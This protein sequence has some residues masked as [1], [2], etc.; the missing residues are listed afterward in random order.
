MPKIPLKKP[1]GLTTRLALGSRK[2]KPP[3]NHGLVPMQRTLDRFRQPR[4]T[5][6]P[7]LAKKLSQTSLNR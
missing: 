6:G 7:D 1:P 4:P 5:P 3:P 2:P